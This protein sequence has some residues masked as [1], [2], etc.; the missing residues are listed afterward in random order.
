MSPPPRDRA[1]WA[2]LRFAIIGPLLAAP[3]D[4][5][6]LRQALQAL[7]TKTWRHPNT[8]LPITFATSTLERWFYAARNARQSDP[9]AALSTRARADAGQFRALPAALIEAIHA[10][11]EA[12]PSWSCQLHYDNLQAQFGAPFPSYATLR[13]HMKARGL[14]RQPSAPRPSPGAQAAALHLQSVEVRSYEVAQVNALWHLDFHHGSRKV[15]TRAGEWVKPLL[16]CVMDDRS[17]LVCHLQWYLD[18]TC[19]TLVHGFCQALQRRRLPRA[20]MTDNGSAMTAEE[21][22]RGL[23][24]LGILHETTLPYSPYQNAKQERFWGNV[25]GRL[26][27]MLEG[28]EELSLAVLNL[29]TQAWVEGD[30]HRALNTE[31]GATPVDCYVNGREVGR[32]CPASE[33]LRRAFRMEVNRKQRKTDG[34]LSLEGVR[35]EIPARFRHL[36][37]V[38]VRYARWD[39]SRVDL[40]D[41]RSGAVLCALSPLDKSANANGERRALVPTKVPATAAPT[42]AALAPLMQKLLAEY[43]ATGLPPAYLPIDQESP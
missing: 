4:Q 14:F 21:F 39:L 20:L 12:H 17:R 19:E 43:A 11:F 25:E 26:M 42:R 31:L 5:G 1:R 30:Y 28:V 13:R 9:V 38:A 7:S 35:F 36:E 18:E 29:A 8:G 3:P 6:E 15:L 27:A 16:L 32:D 22:T 23:Q 40:I 24:D 34:T 33:T 10:Q 37:R 41:D 2:H